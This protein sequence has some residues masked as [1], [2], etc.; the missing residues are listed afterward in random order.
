MA[1]LGTYFYDGT[2]FASA[3]V[4]C[5]DAALSNPAPD[6]WYAQGGVY[7]QI[8]GGVL[9]GVQTCASCGY[10]CNSPAVTT[11][12][13]GKY[14]VTVDMGATQG[15]VIAEF[16]VGTN[17]NA[18]CTWTYNGI[19]A[20]EYS[21]PAY[22]Y[23]QGVIGDENCCG[24]DNLLGSNGA[25][26]TGAEYVNA[27][28][29]FNPV[30]TSTTW[31]PYLNK[32]AGGVDLTPGG[33]Y[34][35]TIMVIP[36]TSTTLNTIVFEIDSPNGG[37]SDWSLEVRCPADL[38]QFATTAYTPLSS[39]CASMCAATPAPPQPSMYHAIVDPTESLP[40]FPSVHDWVFKDIWGAQIA[41]DGCYQIS[42]YYP[43]L[44]TG[45]LIPNPPGVCAEVANGVI[46]KFRLC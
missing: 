31:G 37:G 25:T 45:S 10:A 4:L 44:T 6:G 34:G 38:D 16:T 39:G 8:S 17:S 3:T 40:G 30:G 23:C 28:A 7:R 43:N 33:A 36:K 46:Q 5:T 32:A 13:F 27:G 1:T 35:K 20:T 19:T 15:A 11:S 9:G 42:T 24:L 2:S 41:D 12:V 14:Y 22:G 21:S 18:R 26:F 29:T